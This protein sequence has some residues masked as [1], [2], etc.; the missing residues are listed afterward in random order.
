VF[1]LIAVAYGGLNAKS[2]QASDEDKITQELQQAVQ[3][4]V[5]ASDAPIWAIH[6]KAVDQRR[7]SSSGATGK[8]R[9]ILD[10][11][12]TRTQRGCHPRFSFEAKRLYQKSGEKEYLGADGLGAY[13]DGTYRP[14]DDE[15]GMLGYVQEDTPADWADRLGKE[16]KA[17]EKQLAVSPGGSWKTFP[18][19]SALPFTFRSGHNRCSTGKQI[20]MYHVLLAFC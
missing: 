15:A 6:F 19:V 10:L 13:L 12:L 7:D 16:M 11:L 17:N 18:L 5:E 14:E 1:A 20:T 4:F 9:P 3:K 8:H 2:Y